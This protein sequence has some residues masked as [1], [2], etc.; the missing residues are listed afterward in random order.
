MLQRA[1]KRCRRLHA[2]LYP[3][4]EVGGENDMKL[5]I[6]AGGHQST[7]SSEKEGI[8]KP[9]VEI[10]GKPILWHIMKYFS[11]FG[12]REF[13][14]CG[15]YKI[16]VLKEYFLN[17]Y[18]YQS[19]ITVDLENNTI[20]IHKKRTENWE[21]SVVDTGIYASTAQRVSRVQSFIGNEDFMVTYGDCLSDLCVP[22]VWKM[23]QESGKI[24]TLV[25]AR[26]SGRNVILSVG[27]DGELMQEPLL[28]GA[29]AWTSANI[30]V[31]SPKIFNYLQ[32][33][34]ELDY[35]VKGV[36]TDHKQVSLYKHPGFWM[37]VETRRDLVAMENQWN[38]RIAPW[39]K[40]Q[41]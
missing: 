28:S 22:D 13:I 24:C 5:V 2:L 1:T 26:P 29:D 23:H 14:I 41:D 39:K 30:Y 21:V 10:G 37:P 15:G 4:A 17:Y 12:I 18:I 3:D 34:Y 40:W 36:L 38:A 35:F 20:E 11:T 9:M 33:S 31:L 7:I 25:A 6:L 8:P 32:G 19:D 16:N 27:E